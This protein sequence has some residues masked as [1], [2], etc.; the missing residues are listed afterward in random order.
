M[1]IQKEIISITGR[2]G[3]TLQITRAVETITESYDA[4]VQ[5]Q[6]ALQF[7]SGDEI[8][9][10]FTAQDYEDL[11]AGSATVETNV[12]AYVDS[13]IADVK[14]EIQQ[15]AYVYASSS[16]GTDAYAITVTPTP[17]IVAGSSFTFRADVE[18][19]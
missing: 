10:V 7:D 3:D 8:V 2:T 15:Q 4:N 5:T 19:T 9:G 12:T 11:Q 14:S 18:N 13:E 1:E 16:T 17:T 6:N